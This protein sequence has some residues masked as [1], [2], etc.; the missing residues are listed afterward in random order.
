MGSVLVSGHYWFVKQGLLVN[1]T[2]FYSVQVSGNVPV[3]PSA[4]QFI[5]FKG[6]A[7]KCLSECLYG[8]FL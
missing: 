2:G 8:T 4:F 6:L 3:S 5:S 1:I 7:N